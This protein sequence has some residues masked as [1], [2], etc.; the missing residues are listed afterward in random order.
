MK[1]L[2]SYGINSYTDERRT[3]L[4]QVLKENLPTCNPKQKTV[5]WEKVNAK[6]R[7]RFPLWQASVT[8]MQ[9]ESGRLIDFYD[10]DRAAFCAQHEACLAESIGEYIAARSAR[11]I[12]NI[13]DEADVRISLDDIVVQRKRPR[14]RVNTRDDRGSDD[15]VQRKR[16]RNARDDPELDDIIQRKP[17]QIGEMIGR[18][19]NPFFM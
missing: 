16:P 7:E 14:S 15:I 12:L 11:R 1:E 2:P 10:Q 17:S 4:F 18:Y 13:V 8:S 6:V 9:K 19:I 5:R 3:R